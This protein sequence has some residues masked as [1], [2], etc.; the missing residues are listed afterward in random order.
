MARRG[1]FGRSPRPAASLQ[2]TIISIAREMQNQRDQ[3]VMDAWQKG[4]LFEGKKATDEFVLNYWK[5]RAGS[6][7]K[8]DPL[9]DTYHNAQTELDYSI[10]ESKVRTLYAQG[11]MSDSQTA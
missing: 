8:D 5:Q 1:N 4:G 6:V 9:Y 10:H 2:N 7:S 3:N 11:K